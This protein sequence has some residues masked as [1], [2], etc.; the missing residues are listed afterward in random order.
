MGYAGYVACMG[1]RRAAYR[2]LV[3]RYEERNHLEDLRVVGRILLVLKPLCKQLDGGLWIGLD[4]TDL[5]QDMD[6]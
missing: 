3:E 5:A 1:D 2:V 4:W 6:M